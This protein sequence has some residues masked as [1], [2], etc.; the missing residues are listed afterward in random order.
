M[1]MAAA[2]DADHERVVNHVIEREIV[3]NNLLGKFHPFIAYIVA[4]ENQKSKS[5]AF[6]GKKEGVDGPFSARIVRETSL[7]HGIRFL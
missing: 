5:V 7:L 6:G 4:N 1:G 3:F 2:D